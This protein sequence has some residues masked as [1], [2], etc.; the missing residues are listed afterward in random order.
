MARRRRTRQ[1]FQTMI[2]DEKKTRRTKAQKVAEW[3]KALAVMAVKAQSRRD[4]HYARTVGEDA[5]DPTFVVVTLET[6]ERDK[7]P[8]TTY[9]YIAITR[10]DG[11]GVAEVIPL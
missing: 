9:E 7:R 1:D 3:R 10:A 4:G 2:L 6:T 11:Y 8:G 5:T